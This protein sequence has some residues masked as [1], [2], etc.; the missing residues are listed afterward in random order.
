[1]MI[2]AA[3]I[4]LEGEM[5]KIADSYSNVLKHT[6]IDNKGVFVDFDEGDNT[7]V[8]SFPDVPAKFVNCMSK[9]PKSIKD[10]KDGVI[11][12]TYEFEKGDEEKLGLLGFFNLEFGER[13]KVTV[14]EFCNM[15][16]YFVKTI[17]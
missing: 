5:L 3:K 15:D 14:V 13:E 1:M 7:I 8:P 9:A 10:L 17:T 16:Q 4:N 6:D 2:K 12:E 11:I